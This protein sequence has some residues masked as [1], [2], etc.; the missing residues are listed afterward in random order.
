[1][2][3]QEISTKWIKSALVLYNL[4]I[5]RQWMSIKHSR[6]IQIQKE[7]SW[8]CDCPNLMTVLS[9]FWLKFFCFYICVEKYKICYWNS[10]DNSDYR[11]MTDTLVHCLLKRQ[12]RVYSDQKGRCFY[13]RY[14]VRRSERFGREWTDAEL[15]ERRRALKGF[16]SWQAI[17][18]WHSYYT[19]IA[20]LYLCGLY[21]GMKLSFPFM[22]CRDRGEW[23]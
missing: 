20:A 13:M 8:K 19:T 3:S 5:Y 22:D 10:T 17:A 12:I 18:A 21:W 11:Q 16:P 2:L 7:H 23:S 14:L 4:F 6:Q 15:S 1:M 9:S